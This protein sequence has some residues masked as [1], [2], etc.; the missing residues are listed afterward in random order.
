M[1]MG[2]PGMLPSLSGTGKRRRPLIAL[3][4]LIACLILPRTGVQAA[5]DLARGFA[6]PPSWARPWVYWFW[7]NGNITREGITLDLEAMRRVGIGGVLIM[8][9]DQGTPL[10]PVPFAGERWRE[11]FQH[12]VR[13][14]Q[15]LGLQVNMN[16]DAGWCGTGGPWVKP[17]HAMQKVVWSATTVEGGSQQTIRPAMPPTVHGYYRD[18]AV[19]AFP[20]PGEYRIPD[21][22]P[23]SALVRGDIAPGAR[24]PDAPLD[25]VVRRESIVNL[26]DRLQEDGSLTW[27]PP[28]GRW[29]VLRLGHTPTGAMNAPSPEL[30]RGL[31]VDKLSKEAL[32]AYWE[33]FPGKL[34]RDNE[35]LVGSTFVAVHIDSWE[36][37]S[38]NW[39]PRFAEEFRR[40]RG[41]DITPYLPVFSG[42]VVESAD[43]SDRF[44]FDVRRTVSD[45]L[46]EN[47]AGHMREL[48]HRHGM[49][50][51]IEAYGDTTVDNL[52]Y[53]GRAD[54]PMGEF[55][56]WPPYGAGNTLVEMAGA[57]HVYG[58]RIVGAEAFTAGDGEKWLYHPGS[59]KA[60]GDWAFSMGINR[61][62]F[63]RYALQ[64]W[65]DR[66]PGVSMGP[67]GLH[68]E[69]TQTWWEQSGPWH[70][71][72]S[73]C[74]YLL[75]QGQPVADVLALAPEGAAR[76]FNPP[77]QLERAGYKADGCS[78]EVILGGCRVE[79]GLIVT[80][81]GV[82]Y[83]AL[84]LPAVD[85]ATPELMRRLLDLAR[86]GALLVGTLPSRS[87]SLAGYP[88]CD[89][90]V[91]RLAEAIRR[92][93]RLVSD[94]PVQDVLKGMGVPPD[95]QADRVLNWTHRRIGKAEVYFV[96]NPSPY[97]ARVECEFRV[98][99]MA[100]EI[101]D[102]LSGRIREAALYLPGKA[103]TRVQLALEP[104]GSVFVVFRKPSRGDPVV[105]LL[106]NGRVIWPAQASAPRIRVLRAMW[107]P[108]GDAARTKD[109]TDQVQRMVDRVGPSFTVAE[110]AAEGDP[111]FGVVKTLEV[112]YM[113][114]GRRFSVRATDPE[115]IRFEVPNA[116]VSAARLWLDDRGRIQGEADA[117]GLYVAVR[118]SGAR[119]RFRCGP[120]PEPTSV[121]GPW[122]VRFQPGRGAP[123]AIELKG[124]RCW[125]THPDP[126]VRHFSG[127]ATY[128]TR[129]RWQPT[130]GGSRGL[131]WMLDLGRVEVIAD[132]RLNGRPLGTLWRAPFAVDVSEILRP[133]WNELE[134]AV[135]N[136]WP[137]RMIGDEQLPEDSRRH[138][139]GT[140]VEWPDWLE[141]DEPSPTGR[142]TFTTW[143]LWSGDAPLQPSGLL[144]PVRIRAVREVSRTAK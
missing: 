79:K 8:E 22:A 135:T 114:S 52:A 3:A 74:Q 88:A 1:R 23:K 121:A 139:N 60:M 27:T 125:T 93:G 18:I 113:S 104:A 62:V 76:T 11:L 16:N 41:Y 19:L 102:P 107:G 30:G 140:L 61:F 68:Y 82:R 12:V 120:P 83:R 47:Y 70:R 15:R 25:A 117:P 105:R 128:R 110:L 95:F 132:V 101:W 5:E 143:R 6:A 2:L 87:P 94:R 54:E 124:L 80:P 33:N 56:S 36:T 17:E 92:T 123:E 115:V 130:A 91:A 26:T 43:V 29:T 9:V 78:S 144:G 28:P 106:H 85:A 53:A 65:R 35:G 138:A 38:Q 69:R 20:T 51:T 100:P 103:T 97:G 32:D 119:E 34:V 96:A 111:A 58:K 7:L 50:L 37:G 64:P 4:L 14:A 49:R 84:L 77:P 129:F 45:L 136:L 134:V 10:G 112:E 67:W 90:E 24:S 99:G 122:Q 98:T 13:E 48:A 141:R 118:R 142:I 55:W 71:Y 131:R 57:A 40:R 137:N 81:G 89:D 39:T 42:Y 127:T 86:S 75:Q 21:I 66:A 133:G 46:L 72:L 109:V 108:A 116:L 44:L 126:G 63:H 31:E 59:I 73:R